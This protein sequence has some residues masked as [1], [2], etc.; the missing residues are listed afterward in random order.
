MGILDNAVSNFQS[1]EVR[2]IEVPEWG[3]EEEA[4][5]IYVKPLTLQEQQKVFKIS[6]GQELEAMPQI[7]IMKALNSEGEKLFTMKDKVTLMN[8]VDPT[9]VI[10]VATDILGDNDPN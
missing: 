4:L 6:Q 1:R 9:V 8:K 3:T 2:I 5:Q 10:N 7:L